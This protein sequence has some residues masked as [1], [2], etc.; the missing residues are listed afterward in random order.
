MIS[1]TIKFWLQRI[2]ILCIGLMIAVA[3]FAQGGEPCDPGGDPSGGDHICP[4]DSW[5]YVLIVAVILIAA[6]KAYA[7][8]KAKS[9]S[10]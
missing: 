4:I 7:I 9:V 6:K 3:S 10:F 5:V 8:K 2:T 1:T